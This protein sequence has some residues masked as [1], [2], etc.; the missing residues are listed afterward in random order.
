MPNIHLTQDKVVS[1]IKQIKGNIQMQ[2]VILNIL[3][4]QLPENYFDEWI[5]EMYHERVDRRPYYYLEH[6]TLKQY[7]AYCLNLDEVEDY[8][9]TWHGGP[10]AEEFN[11]HALGAA[12]RNGRVYHGFLIIKRNEKEKKNEK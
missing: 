8:I 6:A 10:E 4:E 5:K 11:R 9:K 7:K 1:I 3:A 2:H 12:I